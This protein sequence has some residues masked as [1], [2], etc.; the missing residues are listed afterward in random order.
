MNPYA[1]IGLDLLSCFKIF[2]DDIKYH[3]DIFQND[4]NKSFKDNH[5]IELLHTGSGY[6]RLFIPHI[7]NGILN[8]DGDHMIIRTD[9]S[10]AESLT[11]N[12][13]VY[14]MEGSHPGYV[15]MFKAKMDELIVDQVMKCSD[16]INQCKTDYFTTKVSGLAS[17]KGIISGPSVSQSSLVGSSFNIERDFVFGL[18]YYGWP[19]QA[20]EWITRTRC[21]DWPSNPTVQRI[22]Q[23]GIHIVPVKS[24]NESAK[25]NEWRLSFSAAELELV[26]I[27]PTKVKL[28][29]AILKSFIKIDLKSFQPKIFSSYQL[30]TTLFWWMESNSNQNI[31]KL[32]IFDIE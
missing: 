27:I 9:L 22:K 16:F 24:H 20:K 19:E 31:E 28:S 30:K 2:H 6:E 13:H 29:Y 5:N 3:M 21:Y 7:E 12:M 8:A 11:G 17:R 15:E 1:Q 26:K 25:D 14:M 4:L 32:K 10:V 23:N 18:R